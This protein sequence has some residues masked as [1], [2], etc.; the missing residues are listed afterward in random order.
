MKIP[1]LPQVQETIDIV[2]PVGLEE[3][4]DAEFEKD[5]FGSIDPTLNTSKDQ[6]EDEDTYFI[7]LFV[8]HKKSFQVAARRLRLLAA[9][10]DGAKDDAGGLMG[11]G[12]V[13]DDVLKDYIED[14]PDFLFIY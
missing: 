6:P 12:K 4:D 10:V 9:L 13:F 11:A 5:T 3:I 8:I 1:S 14:Y 2:W 7:D